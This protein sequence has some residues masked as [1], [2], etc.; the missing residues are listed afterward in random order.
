MA[1]K[2][3]HRSVRPDAPVERLANT[4]APPDRPRRHHAPRI[5]GR[6]LPTAP[7]P[8]GR[9]AKTRCFATTANAMVTNYTRPPRRVFRLARR[10]HR[11]Q[12]VI[13]MPKL[14]TNNKLH[15][16]IHQQRPR[17]Q[18]PEHGPKNRPEYS[19]VHSLPLQKS[20]SAGKGYTYRMASAVRRE[21][22]ARSPER[23]TARAV[24]RPSGT[25]IRR[26]DA[27]SGQCG[28]IHP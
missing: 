8:V 10:Q 27:Q 9:L 6:A 5:L 4:R 20:G 1:G 19:I 3:V 21:V 14:D 24:C 12:G 7:D 11:A 17:D 28:S 22:S 18:S 16:D 26:R 23:T 25:S 15:S 13:H 2:L